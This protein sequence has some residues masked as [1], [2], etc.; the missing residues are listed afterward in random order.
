MDI[1]PTSE[2]KELVSKNQC[3]TDPER[4]KRDC[5][6]SCR[7]WQESR[8]KALNSYVMVGDEHP[9]SELSAQTSVGSKL[10]F[11]RFDGHL[12]IVTNAPRDCRDGV[13]ERTLSTLEG[14]LDVWSYGLEIVLFT[15]VNPNVEEEWDAAEEHGLLD[16]TSHREAVKKGRRRLHVMEEVKING[17]NTHPVFKYL[18]DAFDFGEDGLSM[19]TTTFF[20][21]SPDGDWIKANVGLSLAGLKRAISL[22]LDKEL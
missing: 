3:Q 9:F 8:S 11:E 13:T 22:L 7:R 17:P 18:K 21:V 20:I 14:L 1:L 12:T 2:C 4:M 15:F 5:P 19:D 16:C 10:E 6:I